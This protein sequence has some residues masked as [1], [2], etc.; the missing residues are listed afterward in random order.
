MVTIQCL[1]SLKLSQF[2]NRAYTKEEIIVVAA[3]VIPFPCPTIPWVCR[4]KCEVVSMQCLLSF[5]YRLDAEPRE[6]RDLVS[7]GALSCRRPE[8]S[9]GATKGSEAH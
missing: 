7:R 2:V 5:K 4:I 8:R 3:A 9:E 6:L 1:S